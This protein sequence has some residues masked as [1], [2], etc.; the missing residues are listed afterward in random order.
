M[1]KGTSVGNLASDGPSSASNGDVNT[2]PDEPNARF[3][4]FT[5]STHYTN[6]N[7]GSTQGTPGTGG[8]MYYITETPCPTTGY[9]NSGL[10][11]SQVYFSCLC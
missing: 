7:S 9:Y 8:P 1:T 10:S 3:D 4:D 11:C 5:P 2:D 6:G